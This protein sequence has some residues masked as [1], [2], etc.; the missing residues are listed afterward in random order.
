MLTQPTPSVQ[1]NPIFPYGFVIFTVSP[2]SLP[3][4]LPAVPQHLYSFGLP[5]LSIPSQTYQLHLL[6][7]SST[8]VIVSVCVVYVLHSVRIYASGKIKS[9]ESL[10]ENVWQN[11]V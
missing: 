11:G 8:G 4:A 6:E 7:S 9:H 2:I 10:G 1:L 3:F 5:L